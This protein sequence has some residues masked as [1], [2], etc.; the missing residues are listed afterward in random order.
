[1]PERNLSCFYFKLLEPVHLW[2]GPWFPEHELQ[3]SKGPEKVK[4]WHMTFI[5]TQS[6]Y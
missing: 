1:M 2:I 6:V 4:T 5:T 3:S